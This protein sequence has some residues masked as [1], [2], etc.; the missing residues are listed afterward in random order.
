MTK[1]QQVL[2]SLTMR[3]AEAA[4]LL[5]VDQRTASR[6]VKEGTFPIPVLH[7]NGMVRVCRARF[8][9]HLSG[10]SWDP[11][12]VVMPQ[13]GPSWS[14][15]PTSTYSLPEA[16]AILGISPHT[17]RTWVRNTQFPVPILDLSPRLVGRR[18]LRDLIAGDREP[19]AYGVPPPK[20]SGLMAAY[21]D[22]MPSGRATGLAAPLQPA[23][24]RTVLEGLWRHREMLGHQISDL[25]R[26]ASDLGGDPAKPRY[27]C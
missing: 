12:R 1:G 22:A 18:Q 17:A 5:G 7:L 27:G 19:G 14:K 2:P 3:I 8:E 11:E 25:D 26:I 23:D 13:T 24:R 10:D 21:R 20:P 4:P 15:T 9:S 16:A 6:W